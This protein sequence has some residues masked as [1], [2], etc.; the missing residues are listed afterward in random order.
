MSARSVFPRSVAA[1][2][3][4]ALLFGASST[5]SPATAATDSSR[6]YACVAGN[7]K[8]LQLTT[9]NAHCPRGQTKIVWNVTGVEGPR[10]PKGGTGS[11]GARGNA[12]AKG[13]VGAR[14]D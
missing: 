9:K 7:S 13:D 2:C 11:T 6:V 3:V 12:G 4:A 10:G 1:V 8:T 5:V 14:G